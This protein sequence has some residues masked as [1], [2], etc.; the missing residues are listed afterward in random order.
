MRLRESGMGAARLLVAV[1]ALAALPGCWSSEIRR[2]TIDADGLSAWAGQGAIFGAPDS[3][4]GSPVL[5]ASRL[6]ELGTGDFDGVEEIG[7]YIQ[8]QNSSFQPID[9]AV[10]MHRSRVDLSTLL[11]EG[12]RLT[13]PIAVQPQTAFQIDAR[14]YRTFAEGFEEAAELIRGGDFYLYVASEASSFVINGNV[15]TISILVSVSS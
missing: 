9:I 15:P 14:N 6:P 8:L 13:R 3:L 11:A 4:I 12:V 5:L 10:Y 2:V 1:V 7:I